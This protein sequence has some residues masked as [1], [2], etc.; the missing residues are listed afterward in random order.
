MA[1]SISKIW[2]G[3]AK[4]C[5][6]TNQVDSPHNTRKSPKLKLKDAID[7]NSFTLAP[8]WK[9]FLMLSIQC[10]M[11]G[12]MIKYNLQC[13]PATGIPPCMV[14]RTLALDLKKEFCSAPLFSACTHCA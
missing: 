7:C 6:R 12:R 5:G 1:T 8:F 3:G 9:S 2:L 4:L 11:L 13:L 14:A 10:R